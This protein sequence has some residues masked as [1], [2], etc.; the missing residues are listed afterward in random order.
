[1]VMTKAWPLETG[2]AS[3]RQVAKA[4]WWKTASLDAEQNGQGV[5]V[6]TLSGWPSTERSSGE[7]SLSSWSV[8]GDE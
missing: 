5:L 1:M 7:R 4:V 6:L 8:I 3:Q 2:K